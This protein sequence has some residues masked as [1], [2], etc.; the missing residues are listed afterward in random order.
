MRPGRLIAALCGTLL[1]SDVWAQDVGGGTSA[2]VLAEPP[3]PEPSFWEGGGVRVSDTLTF[4]PRFE[5]ETAYQTNVFRAD[6]SDV[7]PY[8]R[9]TGAVGAPLIR[10][11]VGGALGT[12]PPRTL[13]ISA[14][15]ENTASPKLAF[16]GEIDLA[17]NQYIHDTQEVTGSSDLGINLLADARVNPE[18]EFTVLIRDAFTRAVRPPTAESISDQDRDKNEFTLGAI[19]KPGGGAIQGYGNYIFGFEFFEGLNLG[20]RLSHTF[21]LG[22][23]WQWLPKTQFS[24]DSS[25]GIVQP[26]DEWKSGSMPLRLMVG[27]STLITPTF[28]TVIKL[29]YGN[30][31]Y[32]AGPSY[33]SYL[34]Q[35]EARWALGPIARF[36]FGYAHDFADALIGN[37]YSDH[38]F[39]ARFATQIA[40]RWQFRGKGEI[41]L[42][43]YDGITDVLGADFCQDRTSCANERNDI[44]ARVDTSLDYQI[45]AWLY[46]GAQF[47]FESNTTASFVISNGDVDSNGYVWSEFVI[48]AAAKF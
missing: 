16:R 6:D 12:R 33:N 15:G 40:G 5:L 31:F 28:G 37:Y 41:A 1:A 36:A 46:A 39:Y 11:G 19:W 4:H 32:D 27:T 42:R 23:R 8:G 45:N 24:F 17:W 18:G 34:A 43:D 44:I 25:L 7:R 14:P 29:G 13:D 30:G 20:T 47:L 9:G 48:R 35:V 10:L 2:E 26:Q 21:N 38:R 22:V 3:E